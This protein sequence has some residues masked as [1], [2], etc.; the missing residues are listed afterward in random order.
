MFPVISNYSNEI[1]HG[2][3]TPSR[4]HNT[5]ENIAQSEGRSHGCENVH[6]ML[7]RWSFA[8]P[9]DSDGNDFRSVHQGPT[10]LY[11]RPAGTLKM[12]NNLIYNHTMKIITK[13]KINLNGTINYSVP[14]VKGYN[15]FHRNLAVI[16]YGNY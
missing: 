7:Q 4:I 1:M 15:C 14:F 8:I 6:D 12:S 9:Y 13:E 11:F 3:G 10:D 2:R 5:M 16:E